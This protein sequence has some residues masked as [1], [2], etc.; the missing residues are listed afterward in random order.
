MSGRRVIVGVGNRLRGDDRAGLEVAE[1][2]RA[3]V[4]PDVEVIALEGDP[5]PLLELLAEAEL[6]L[7][8]DAV[9]A[10]AEPGTV[11]RFDAGAEPIPGNVSGSSTHAFGVGET[12]EL[13]RALG[14]LR[15]RVLVYGIAAAELGAGEQLSAAV[16]AQLPSVAEQLLADLSL[17]GAQAIAK[18][19]EEHTHA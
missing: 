1:R 12:I 4:P 19:K 14:E 2:L 11:Y 18:T 3:R 7:V 6:V 10:D 15:A 8:V 9:S 5:T 16:E 17:P 13:A